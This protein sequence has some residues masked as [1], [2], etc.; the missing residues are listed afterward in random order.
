MGLKSKIQDGK[1]TSNLAH[2][3]YEGNVH[4]V[5]HPHPP[6]EESIQSFPF[7]ARMSNSNYSPPTNMNVSGSLASPIDFTIEAEND[8]DV[9]IK[10]LFVEIEDSGSMALN[11]FGAL[12]ELTN[13]VAMYYFTQ[14]TGLYELHE[15]IKTN[16]EFI[17][18]GID[19]H[20]IGTGTEAYLADVSGG[21]T[22][23]S[24][25]PIIDWGEMCG[26]RYGL[27]LKK[28]TTDKLVF[29]IQDNL[30]GLVTFDAIAYGIRI[31]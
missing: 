3:D 7:R 25:L 30:T 20:G 16:K 28:G 17:R 26:M 29:R 4:V 8:Y 22:S 13:G 18:I 5:E 21:G 24:Y 27:R 12:S 31:K 2:V 19:T 23:K 6:L 10:T 9:F 1:G 11:K 15:G 14:E